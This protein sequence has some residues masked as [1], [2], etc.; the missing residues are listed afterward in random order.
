MIDF[1][2]PEGMADSV[3]HY[4]EYEAPV[5]NKGEI[6]RYSGIPVATDMSRMEE[7]DDLVDKV[8]E[9]SKKEFTYR[10]VYRYFDISDDDELIGIFRQSKDLMKNMHDCKYGMIFAATVGA[11][12]DR[13]ITRYKKIDSAMALMMQ[14]HGAERAESLCDRFC[15]D[16]KKAAE[17]K[18]YTTHPRYSPGFGDLPLNVQPLLLERVGAEKRLGITLGDSYLMSPSKSVTAVIGFERIK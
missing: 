6:L 11:G 1:I 7:T 12:I 13:L 15:A 17:E 3:A 16:V 5:I 18:G 4:E 8:I 10:V 9:L 2:I 14:A